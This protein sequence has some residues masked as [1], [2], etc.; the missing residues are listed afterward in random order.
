M[1][2]A[3]ETTHITATKIP[4]NGLRP[5]PLS[6]CSTYNTKEHEGTIHLPGPH[7]S[8]SIATTNT[9]RGQSAYR[10]LCVNTESRANAGGEVRGDLEDGIFVA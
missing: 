2:V 4:S 3:A 7:P 9:Q 8:P 10:V 5:R 1:S 6:F